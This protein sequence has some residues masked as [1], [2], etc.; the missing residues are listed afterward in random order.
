MA[1]PIVLALHGA[2]RARHDIRGD[3][4]LGCAAGLIAA[5][6]QGTL[7][8]VARQTVMGYLYWG[9]AALVY[10][11]ARDVRRHSAEA[12]PTN[13]AADARSL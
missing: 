6:V 11:M 12:R 5:D 7:E 10:E 4:L 3:V 8:W 13:D 1:V 9:V 2:W